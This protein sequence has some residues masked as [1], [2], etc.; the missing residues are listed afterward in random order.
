T[1]Q[2]DA[3]TGDIIAD[4]YSAW[5]PATQNFTTVNALVLDGYT[6]SKSSVEKTDVTATDKD[7]VETIIYRTGVSVVDPKD[8]DNNPDTPTPTDPVKPTDPVPN[9]P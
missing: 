4:T 2:V 7:T 8:P 6:A 1:V 5:S 3:V 9:D